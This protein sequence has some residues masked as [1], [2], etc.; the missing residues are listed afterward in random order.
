[1]SDVPS[2]SSAE[3]H[4]PAPERQTPVL[5]PSCGQV[6]AEPLHVSA[7]SQTPADGR[8]VA[9]LPRNWLSGHAP[10]VPSQLSAASQIPEEPR[11]VTPPSSTTSAGQLI[12]EPV[13]TS[14]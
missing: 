3:S 7:A 10:E 8:H 13:Q 2:Q 4:T 9:W 1:S 5:L 12:V 11:Q 14:V 6:A